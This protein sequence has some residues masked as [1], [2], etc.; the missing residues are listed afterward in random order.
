MIFGVYPAI[1]ILAGF[2][3]APCVGAQRKP[4]ENDRLKRPVRCVNHSGVPDRWHNYSHRSAAGKSVPSPGYC[5]ALPAWACMA[6]TRW[7]R[8][9]WEYSRATSTGDGA[10]SAKFSRLS[11]L[12]ALMRAVP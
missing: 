5:A 10:R 1:Q 8:V 12:R 3:W 2:G 4:V 11:F 6:A 7:L 9:G